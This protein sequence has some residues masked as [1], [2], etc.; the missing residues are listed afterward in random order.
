MEQNDQSACRLEKRGRSEPAG[1]WVNN[2][3]GVCRL[4]RVR[5]HRLQAEVPSGGTRRSSKASAV[6]RFMDFLGGED[7]EGDEVLGER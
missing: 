2:K 4:R 1:G 5:R 7:S 3:L 6:R